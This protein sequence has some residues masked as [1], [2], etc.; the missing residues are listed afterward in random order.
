AKS[1][2]LEDNWQGKRALLRKNFGKRKLLLT[3]SSRG[4]KGRTT[5]KR[6]RHS[7]ESL[8]LPLPEYLTTTPLWL[9]PRNFHQKVGKTAYPRRKSCR[10][11]KKIKGISIF[12]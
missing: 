6:S 2:S 11:K 10:P 8:K 9:F 3:K 5:N 1:I 4:L 12:S 7:L